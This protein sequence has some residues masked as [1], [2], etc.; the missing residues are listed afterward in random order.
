MP[1]DT[2]KPCPG[3]HQGPIPDPALHQAFIQAQQEAIKLFIQNEPISGHTNGCILWRMVTS[4]LHPQICIEF[5]NSLKKA[6]V[7]KIIKPGE[8]VN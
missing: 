4:G 8:A 3:C 2:N 5:M 1:A 7:L 6:S